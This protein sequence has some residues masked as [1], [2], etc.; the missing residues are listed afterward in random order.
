[1]SFYDDVMLLVYLCSFCQ[2]GVVG[3]TAILGKLATRVE[4]CCMAQ[5]ELRLSIPM[6]PISPDIPCQAIWRLMQPRL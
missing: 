1:M 3:E 6:S 4:A 2:M 5:S